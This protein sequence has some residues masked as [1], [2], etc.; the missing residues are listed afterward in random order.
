MGDPR[1]ILGFTNAIAD[2]FRG[3]YDAAGDA[4]QGWDT[5]ATVAKQMGFTISDVIKVHADVTGEGGIAAR[6]GA[7]RDA[8]L[9]SD[10]AFYDQL[11]SVRSAMEAGDKGGLPALVEALRSRFRIDSARAWR[12]R[13]ACSAIACSRGG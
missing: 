11:V 5:T 13:P 10:K 8:A 7:L 9:A 1:E 2:I 3:T 4:R 12:S 6:A